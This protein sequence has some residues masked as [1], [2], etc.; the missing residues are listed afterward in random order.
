[1]QP[2]RSPITAASRFFA[3]QN[4]YTSKLG[5]YRDSQADWLGLLSEY[6]LDRLET[7][8]ESLSTEAQARRQQMLDQVSAC[9]EQIKR[10][11]EKALDAC[12]DKFSQ[13]VQTASVHSKLELLI[14]QFYERKNDYEQDAHVRAELALLNTIQNLFSFEQIADRLEFESAETLGARLA[15]AR[16]FFGNLL[17]DVEVKTQIYQNI[18]LQPVLHSSSAGDRDFLL[19][20]KHALRKPQKSLLRPAPNESESS[21]ISERLAEFKKM[22]FDCKPAPPS[23]QSAFSRRFGS[24]PYGF[25]EVDPSL[26]SATCH[27]MNSARE[28]IVQTTQ[29]GKTRLHLADPEGLFESRSVTGCATYSQTGQTP[30]PSTGPNHPARPQSTGKH[31]VLGTVE[32]RVSSIDVSPSD[33]FLAITI[34]NSVCPQLYSIRRDSTRDSLVRL[35]GLEQSSVGSFTF[36]DSAQGDK[37][38][39]IDSAKVLH[40]FELKTDVLAF[41]FDESAKFLSVYY[42]DPEHVLLLTADFEFALLSIESKT[43]SNRVTLENNFSPEFARSDAGETC[44]S[45]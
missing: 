18:N 19:S 25:A 15:K 40:I 8:V 29:F 38:V 42:A 27:L 36:V 6:T 4:K 5:L 9:R 7:A 11:F 34:T 39:L 35:S 17:V 21:F 14:E 32:G 12:F 31:R 33:K 13:L 30:R 22:V 44:S 10:R 1:M 41:T 24:K 26:D 2:Q 3:S 45:L 20:L 43:L 16:D 28:C 37:L 23:S